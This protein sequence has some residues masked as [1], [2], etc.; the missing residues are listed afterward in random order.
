[1]QIFLLFSFHIQL[2]QHIVQKKQQQKSKLFQTLRTLHDIWPKLHMLTY[3]I[4]KKTKQIHKNVE[5]IRSWP[6]NSR[7]VS[8]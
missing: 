2:I 5:N 6:Q 8:I 1:M 7:E 3:V 4:R